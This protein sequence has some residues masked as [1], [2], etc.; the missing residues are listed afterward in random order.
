MYLGH[1]GTCSAL[2]SS[3]APEQADTLFIKVSD[4]MYASP[5]QRVSGSLENSAPARLDYGLCS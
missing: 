2:D 3:W 1:A 4:D 5:Q